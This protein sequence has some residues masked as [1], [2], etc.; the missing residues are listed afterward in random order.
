MKPKLYSQIYSRGVVLRLSV[1]LTLGSLRYLALP[2]PVYLSSVTQVFGKKNVPYMEPPRWRTFLYLPKNRR[3]YVKNRSSARLLFGI[4][5]N[6][7]RGII[8]CQ[9]AEQSAWRVERS[10]EHTPRLG[11]S[12]SSTSPFHPLFCLFRHSSPLLIPSCTSC[13]LLS[14]L[15]FFHF[16]RLTSLLFFSQSLSFYLLFASPLPPI[17]PHASYPQ[18]YYFSF[19]SYLFSSRYL[20]SLLVLPTF[21]T[22]HY[23]L[24]TLL[25]PSLLGTQWICCFFFF[26]CL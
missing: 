10:L 11:P 6:T 5:S 16:S 2:L 22:L 12:S 1:T 9:N 24:N 15:R 13:F 20:H 25:F 26:L 7:V 4:L 23:E 19:T 8:F 21:I 18:V 3:H 17:L 14:F